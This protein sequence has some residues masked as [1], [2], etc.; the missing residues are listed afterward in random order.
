[1]QCGAAL[2]RSGR[3]DF[4]AVGGRRDCDQWL[5]SLTAKVSKNLL[6]CDCS[7]CFRRQW[8]GALQLGSDWSEESFYRS[9]TESNTL[10]L[11]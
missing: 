10:V 6:I 9:Q 5:N 1:M 3:G 4:V 2:R 8:Y 7:G 11:Q